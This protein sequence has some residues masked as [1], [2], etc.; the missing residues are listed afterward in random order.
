MARAK[1]TST[2]DLYLPP[3]R[4]PWAKDMA[5][6]ARPSATRFESVTT[7]RRE[8]LSAAAAIANVRGRGNATDDGC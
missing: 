1:S 6:S 8:M 4:G 2:S 5:V 7:T 3:Y